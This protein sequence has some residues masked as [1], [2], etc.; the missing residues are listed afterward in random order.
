MAIPW[1]PSSIWAPST[2]TEVGMSAI[3]RPHI[4]FEDYLHGLWPRAN[5]AHAMFVN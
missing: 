4:L 3:A 1:K 2:P 5:N